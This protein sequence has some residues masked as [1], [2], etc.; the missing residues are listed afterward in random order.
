MRGERGQ[1]SLEVVALLPLAAVVALVVF[2]VIAARG[3]GAA[4]DAAAAAGA[5]A[6]VQSGDPAAAA[7]AA[8]PAGVAGRARIVVAGRV[9]RVT[10]RPALPLPGLAALLAARAVADA[11][12]EPGR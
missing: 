12:P 9:V 2:C 10:V 7:R 3:V 4:A 6:L 5:M 1:A 8:L 11:G